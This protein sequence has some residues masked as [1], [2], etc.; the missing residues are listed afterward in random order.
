MGKQKLNVKYE[1]AKYSKGFWITISCTVALLIGAIVLAS[2]VGIRFEF[3]KGIVTEFN[4]HY[5]KEFNA[6][7]T[8]GIIDFTYKGV[9]VVE[10]MASYTNPYDLSKGL[11]FN[12]Q[13]EEIWIYLTTPYNEL[14]NFHHKGPLGF[15]QNNGQYDSGSTSSLYALGIFLF[16]CTAIS[17]LCSIFLGLPVALRTR[18]NKKAA[19]KAATEQKSNEVS[20]VVNNNNNPVQRNAQLA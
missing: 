1:K 12:P 3:V 19:I 4:T 7:N 16:L 13:E 14:Q 18:E 8:T 15:I 17:A 9:H 2:L 10:N 6:G 20:Q 5:M 11:Y